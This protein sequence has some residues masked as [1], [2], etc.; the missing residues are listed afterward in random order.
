[1]R[2]SR[3]VLMLLLCFDVW[4]RG[5][6]FGPTVRDAIGHRSLARVGRSERAAR[7]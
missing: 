5:H 6:T 4:Y 3:L 1:M 7:L 2:W